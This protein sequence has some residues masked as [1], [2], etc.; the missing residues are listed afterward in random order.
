MLQGRGVSGYQLMSVHT[1]N[2]AGLQLDQTQPISE[3]RNRHS[4]QMRSELTS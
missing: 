4:R 2:S 1:D 3:L